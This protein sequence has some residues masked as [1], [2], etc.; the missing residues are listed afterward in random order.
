[1]GK[2][3]GLRGGLRWRTFGLRWGTLRGGSRESLRDGLKGGL[4]GDLPPQ[5]PFPLASP[6]SNF[7]SLY[8]APSPEASGKSLY[9]WPGLASL[10]PT[11]YTKTCPAYAT[12]FVPTLLK[13]ASPERLLRP[14]LASSPASNFFSLF[15][16]PSQEASGNSLFLWPPCFTFFLPLHRPLSEGLGQVSQRS[17]PRP[18]IQ[19]LAPLMLPPSYLPSL[20]PLPRNAFYPPYPPPLLQIPSPF[21]L[22]PLRRLTQPLSGG[23]GHVFV[24][25]YPP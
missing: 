18:H 20:K 11:T 21:T 15:N 7:F 5:N 1:M 4:R 22:P 14:P 6:A 2:G 19:K 25:A 16:A 3:G 12:P 24:Y 9:M 10:A 8:I 17:K 23:L 13:T